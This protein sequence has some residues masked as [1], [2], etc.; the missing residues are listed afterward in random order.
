MFISLADPLFSE[1]SR[2]DWFVR[3]GLTE[4]FR[5]L[6]RFGNCLELL[7]TLENFWELWGVFAFAIEDP[8]AKGLRASEHA[9][10]L[11]TVRSLIPPVSHW[12]GLC[13]QGVRRKGSPT[14]HGVVS[15][16]L[17]YTYKFSNLV[18]NDRYRK[19]LQA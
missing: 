3:Y 2:L 14:L 18:R 13:Q 16:G 11:C 6:I 15:T 17:V 4:L 9:S 5:T 10:T 1:H 8:F 12:L 19:R 7:G